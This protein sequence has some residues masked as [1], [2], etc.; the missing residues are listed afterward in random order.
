MK[1]QPIGPPELLGVDR[2]A[3]NPNRKIL[4]SRNPISFRMMV[5]INDKESKGT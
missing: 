1:K 4:L 3:N 2:V 5:T